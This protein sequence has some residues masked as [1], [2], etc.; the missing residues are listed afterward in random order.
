MQ[1]RAWTRQSNY[2]PVMKALPFAPGYRPVPMVGDSVPMPSMAIPFGAEQTIADQCRSQGGTYSEHCENAP[3][4]TTA[5]ECQQQGG[6]WQGNCDI[7]VGGSLT[8]ALGKLNY[9]VASAASIALAYHG[10]K[11]NNSVGWAIGWAIMGS[12]FWPIAVPIALAQ[13]FGK[14]AK[15]G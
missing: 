14:P 12:M 11:R 5:A 3:L 8:G 1:P 4:A 9:V 15:K 7:Q 2:Q 6:H 13:G 10:Y